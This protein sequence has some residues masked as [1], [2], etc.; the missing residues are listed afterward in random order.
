MEQ[1]IEQLERLVAAG[2]R[3]DD[4]GNF[5]P[6][7]GYFVQLISYVRGTQRRSSPFHAAI[8]DGTHDGPSS[9][10]FTLTFEN[11]QILGRDALVSCFAS[12]VEV[13][14]PTHGG[15]FGYEVSRRRRTEQNWYPPIGAL[16]FTATG[17]GYNL[18]DDDLVDLHQLPHGVLAV[19]KEWSLEAVLTYGEAFRAVNIGMPRSD[20]YSGKK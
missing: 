3:K 1:D 18:P 19:L 11:A 10:S 12:L 13:W 4:A 5:H 17:S 8:S 7:W 15:I 6:S 2:A 16:T 20:A 14:R 9:D